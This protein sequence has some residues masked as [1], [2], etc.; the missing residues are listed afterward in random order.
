MSKLK[1]PNKS[2]I[3]FPAVMWLVIAVT[4]LLLVQRQFVREDI[5]LVGH[6]QL[7][8]QA[9]AN[10]F[11]GIAWARHVLLTQANVQAAFTPLYME[12]VA[13]SSEWASKFTITPVLP[14]G[15]KLVY[16]FADESGKI[17]VNSMNVNPGAATNQKLVEFLLIHHGVG[18]TDA[19]ALAQALIDFIRNKN[20]PIDSLDE[21][22]QLPGMT[23]EIYTR[24]KDDLTIYPLGQISS[25]S[26]V[27]VNVLTA[28]EPV[29]MAF[30]QFNDSRSG[31][32]VDGAF[33]DDHLN[34]LK[35]I[36]LGADGVAYTKDDGADNAGALITSLPGV[37]KKSDIFRAISCGLSDNKQVRACFN[38]VFYRN[39]GV[40]PNTVLIYELRQIQ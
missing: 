2:G 35:R 14:T 5:K 25:P 17:N 28:S 16:G 18:D 34:E 11:S 39:M 40:S 9:L 6:A 37:N 7:K 20:A 15:E 31:G 33:T 1:I 23:N 38:V 30:L 26:Q 12:G 22:R 13:P 8:T 36:Q 21:L 24:I 4:S 32:A 27:G 19:Q 10:A 3:I 29:L